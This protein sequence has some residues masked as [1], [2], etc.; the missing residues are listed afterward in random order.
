MQLLTTIKLISLKPNVIHTLIG[1]LAFLIFGPWAIRVVGQDPSATPGPHQSP[2][3][4]NVLCTGELKPL[5]PGR[6]YPAQ[7]TSGQKHCWAVHLPARHYMHIEVAQKGIDV[8]VQLIDRTTRIPLTEEIDTPTGQAREERLSQVTEGEAD[9]VVVVSSIDERAIQ[10]DYQIKITEWRPSIDQDSDFVIAERDFLKGWLL[11]GLASAN[12]DAAQASEMYHQALDQLERAAKRLRVSEQRGRAVLAEINQIKPN[13]HVQFGWLRCATKDYQEST[14][15][16]SALR[17]LARANNSSEWEAYALFLAKECSESLGRDSEAR[18]FTTE[19][20]SFELKT[21]ASALNMVGDFY[22]A[23]RDFLKGVDLHQRAA[24][25]YHE[26]SL[27]DREAVILT[28]IGQDYF[29]LGMFEQAA[30]QYEGKA[31][32]VQGTSNSVK[33]R[34]KYNLGVVLGALGERSRAFTELSEAYA[35]FPQENA[36]GRM[37]TLHSLGRHYI[38]LGEHEVGRELVNQALALNR[39]QVR[40]ASAAA[41]EYLYLGFSFILDGKETEGRKYTEDALKLWASLND[42]RGQANALYNLGHIAFDQE[43]FDTALQYL[44]QAEQLQKNEPYGLAYS[45]S[46]LGSVYSKRGNLTLA[47]EKFAKALELRGG[48]RQGRIETLTLWARAEASAGNIE[49]AEPMVMDAISLLEELRKNVPGAELRAPF[50]ASFVQVYSLRI[51]LLMQKYRTTHKPGDLE[52]ALTLSDAIHARSLL[53]SLM[54]RQPDSPRALPAD[55]LKQERELLDQ[56][57]QAE[58]RHRLLSISPHKPEELVEAEREAIQVRTRWQQLRDQIDNTPEYRLVRPKL[59]SASQMNTSLDPNTLM[60]QFLLGDERSYVWLT[61]HEKTEGFQLP[62]RKHI[63]T[64]ARS[65]LKHFP[66]SDPRGQRNGD[67]R[68]GEQL[69]SASFEESATELSQMLIGQLSGRLAKKRLVIVADGILHYVPFNALTNLNNRTRKW[70]PLLISH[71][72][73]I[74]PSAAVSAI[75]NEISVSRKPAPQSIALIGDPVYQTNPPVGPDDPT[76]ARAAALLGTPNIYLRFLGYEVSEIEKLQKKLLPNSG[77]RFL[78]QY[79]ANLQ[80]ATSSDLTLFGILHYGAHGVFDDQHPET[81]GL[82]LSIFDRNNDPLLD[83]FL[84]PFH[85][86]RLDLNADLVV[87]SACESALG[88]EVKGE[89]LMSL[90]RAFMRAG[91]S[92]VIASLWV[93]NDA[94]TA[95]LMKE[96]YRQMWTTHREPSPALREAQRRMFN[97]GEPPQIWAAFQ[98]YGDW[99]SQPVSTLRR[100]R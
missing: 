27:P 75:L 94:R 24:Q 44:L 33:A 60:L 15:Q 7:I 12:A 65:F 58:G 41:Y 30:A 98:T 81:S 79:D 11:S 89:G 87:L 67:V 36:E 85:V 53:D 90:T 73:I 57:N 93:V 48:N 49:K 42:D 69:R 95:R 52:E 71:E 31:L 54:V 1:L 56:W 16:F 2:V 59:V 5:E 37:Y 35:L 66:I 40:D 88:K 18:G 14:N 23:N 62:G 91:A 32:K 74:S 76:I 77:A 4:F 19:F 92:R 68:P 96:F 26:A 17:Q 28:K 3:D 6:A 99:K 43:K 25:L 61:S 100:R 97:D 72:I 21:R 8:V 84:T 82:L 55:L 20:N 63:E 80:N 10:P 47:R 9:Y 39:D 78:T 83:N 86:N 38:G 64:A 22:W 45:L 50:F 34:A 29:D 46:S 13:I 51:D 70:E